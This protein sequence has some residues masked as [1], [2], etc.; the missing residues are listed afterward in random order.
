MNWK[1]E[2]KTTGSPG[3]GRNALVFATRE[4]ATEYAYDLFMRWTACEEYRA[5]EVDEPVT[6]TYEGRELKAIE[7][8]Q[9]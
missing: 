9:P 5:A 8:V 7:K 1:P 4:E 6:H 2:M 3:W